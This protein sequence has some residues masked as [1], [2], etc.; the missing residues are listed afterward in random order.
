[1]SLSILAKRWHSSGISLAAEQLREL[2]TAES[3]RA[4]SNCMGSQLSRPVSSV[5]VGGH[6]FPTF[7]LLAAVPRHRMSPYPQQTR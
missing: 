2:S 6:P 5:R 4:H 7:T 1:M 3:L